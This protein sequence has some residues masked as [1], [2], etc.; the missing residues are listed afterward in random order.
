ML[1]KNMLM[2]MIL[3]VMVIGGTLL[4]LSINQPSNAA[5]AI[6]SPEAQQVMAALE[7]AKDAI[8][9]ALKT[10]NVAVLET[11]LVDHPD[12]LKELTPQ[13]VEGLSAFITRIL[14]PSAA[15]DFGY[16]TAMKNKI[17]YRLQGETFVQTEIDKARAAN[18]EF[19]TAD[20]QELMRQHPDK[21]IMMPRAERA[22]VT[23]RPE[24]RIYKSIQIDGD[25]AR[26]K[27]EDVKDRTAILV[28][29]DGKWYVAGIF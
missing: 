27:Y 22:P 9:T 3:V 26:V 7:R 2:A 6:D 4:L 1:R 21:R 18:R 24:Q 16:L 28:R 8:A 10:G 13:E 19:T 23:P 17:T 11:A 5:D 15:K 29:I 12:Y 20:L 14:G 25:K